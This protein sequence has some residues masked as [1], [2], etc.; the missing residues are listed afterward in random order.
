[1]PIEIRELSISTRIVN[2]PPPALALSESQL[3]QLKQQVMQQVMQ[4][5]LKVLKA[6]THKSSFDR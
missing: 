2:T 1:M 3:Q 5:C 4:E 6:R